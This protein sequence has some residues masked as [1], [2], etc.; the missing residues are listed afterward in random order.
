M[1]ISLSSSS[2]VVEESRRMVTECIPASSHALPFIRT[3][4][5]LA[6]SSPTR[7]TARP[8]RSPR[9]R[10]RWTLCATSARI[11]AAIAVPSMTSAGKIHRTRFADHDH[12]DLPGILQLGLDAS[13]DLL[14]ERRHAHIVHLVWPHDHTDFPPSLDRE[15]LLHPAV[16]PG[17]LLDPLEPLHVRLERLAPSSWT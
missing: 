15:H 13:R 10:S 2:C 12:L 4:T 16:A 9:A 3:Y 8:G 7:I 14:R 1:S 17:D 6:G 5:W 11:D